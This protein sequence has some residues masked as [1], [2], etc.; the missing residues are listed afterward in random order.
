[1]SLSIQ[2]DWLLRGII[3]LCA[4]SGFNR[5]VIREAVTFG[6]VL[7]AP[8]LAPV[9]SSLVPW[10]ASTAKATAP[11][12]ATSAAGQPGV[13]GL[14]GSELIG[15]LAVVAA[16][17]LVG[18]LLLRGPRSLTPRLL[19]TVL[20]AVNGFLIAQFAVPRLVPASRLAASGLGQQAPLGLAG[21]SAGLIVVG[22]VMVISGLGVWAAS[23]RPKTR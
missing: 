20:G 6:G 19:G 11:E 18:A 12:A 1:M 10:V 22:V 2:P 15:F 9:L 13:S 7:L 23:G 16:G 14:G 4:L 3:A 5:G 8:V 17:Y 21:A